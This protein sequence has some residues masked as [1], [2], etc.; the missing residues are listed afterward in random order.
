MSLNI[1]HLTFPGI[2]ILSFSVFELNIITKLLTGDGLCILL[3]IIL[4]FVNAPESSPFVTPI[5]TKV[6]SSC[7]RN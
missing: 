1:P 6:A 5:S 2:S 4:L 7:L 3:V